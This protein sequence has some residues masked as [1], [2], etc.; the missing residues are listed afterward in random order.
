MPHSASVSSSDSQ[1]QVSR[2]KRGLG[3]FLCMVSSV[4]TIT[5]VVAMAVQFDYF[6]KDGV[7]AEDIEFLQ[8]FSTAAGSTDQNKD[9]SKP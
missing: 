8:N 7:V 3:L 6:V 5:V 9:V 4:V 2:D 1:P